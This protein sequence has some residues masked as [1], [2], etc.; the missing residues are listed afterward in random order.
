LNQEMMIG[1]DTGV[2]FWSTTTW[3]RL[4]RSPHFI[5][6]CYS[7]SG[8]S[9]WLWSETQGASLF[10]KDGSESLLPL[11]PGMRPLAVSADGRWLAV[12]VEAQRLRILDFVELRKQL[13]N[14]GM[15]WDQK[16]EVRG[17]RS[18]LHPPSAL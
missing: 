17:Q 6:A 13:G 10:N 14:L 3:H 15:D 18:D 4:R 8:D 16:S 9:C 11:G 5:T 1:T 2:E 12:N 7:A